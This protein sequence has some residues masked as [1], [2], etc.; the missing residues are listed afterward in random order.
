MPLLRVPITGKI[1]CSN[2]ILLAISIHCWLEK[3]SAFRIKTLDK[4]HHNLRLRRL[5]RLQ[6]CPRYSKMQLLDEIKQDFA[7]YYSSDFAMSRYLLIRERNQMS[8]VLISYALLCY[9]GFYRAKKNA[10]PLLQDGKWALRVYNIFQVMFS[11]YIACLATKTYLRTLVTT[12]VVCQAMDVDVNK[13][14]NYVAHQTYAAHLFYIRDHSRFIPR[15]IAG[16][17]LPPKFSG[18][19]NSVMKLWKNSHFKRTKTQDSLLS[20]AYFLPSN[21]VKVAF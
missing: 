14:R 8:V 7:K 13:N 4:I 6:H 16:Y 19:Q 15:L 5:Q 10:E 9:W 21:F 12:G 3:W 2:P 20:P 18:K 17:F 11:G 1:V